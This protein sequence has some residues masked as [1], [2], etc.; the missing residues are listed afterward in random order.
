MRAPAR[1]IVASGPFDD[2]RSRDLRFLQ[3]ASRLGELSVLLWPDDLVEKVS[4]SAP[5]F[6]LA[7]RDYFLRAVRF[8]SRVLILENSARSDALP[9][10]LRADIWADSGPAANRE[11]QEFCRDNGLQYRAF[12][13]DELKRFPMP[14]PAP[15]APGEKKVVVTGSFDW[16]HS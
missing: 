6:P 3:E 2:V 8:V 4:G 7:E 11:R 1:Q 14:P 5:I 12:S 13:P 10:G 16:F 15:S 9:P